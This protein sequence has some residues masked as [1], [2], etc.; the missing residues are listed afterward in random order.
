[1]SAD[2]FRAALDAYRAAVDKLALA[3]RK[4]TAARQAALQAGQERISAEEQVARLRVDVDLDDASP[5][6]LTAAQQRVADLAEAVTQNT[7][8]H[9]AIEA[10]LPELRRAVTQANAR[11]H[12][13]RQN[14][15]RPLLDVQRERA[16]ASLAEAFAAY[17][18]FLRL[19]LSC[20]LE[21]PSFLRFGLADEPESIEAMARANGLRA[22]F[23]RY[24]D[25]GS[26][27]RTC[28]DDL[29]AM[30]AEKAEHQ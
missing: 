17:G 1:M 23:R 18:R 24:I 3:E 29:L 13:A 8:Q 10:R 26:P 11:L 22:D 12:G 28:D 7:A 14:A 6:Q 30:L 2:D 16:R 25:D 20:D 21:V 5:D 19:A 27:D 9:K 4:S 15:M